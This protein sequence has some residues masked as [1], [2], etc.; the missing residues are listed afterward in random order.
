MLI[1]CGWFYFITTFS[2]LPGQLISTG[3]SPWR[4]TIALIAVLAAIIVL[5][6]GLF[7][8]KNTHKYSGLLFLSGIV[9][10]II[11]WNIF[12]ATFKI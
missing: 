5:F 2:I 4:L 9:L 1:V 11:A 10:A 8:K 3:G 7:S 6:Y 12:K